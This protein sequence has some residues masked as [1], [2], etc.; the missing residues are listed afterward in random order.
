MRRHFN[1]LSV[2]L[3]VVM[4]YYAFIVV[5]RGSD[6]EQIYKLAKENESL[7]MQLVSELDDVRV[8]GAVWR[9][10]R[11]DVFNDDP[12]QSRIENIPIA[13]NNNED[14][15]SACSIVFDA[16][17]FDVLIVQFDDSGHV[18]VQFVRTEEH[19][20]GYSLYYLIYR[21]PGY[22]ALWGDVDH[23][24]QSALSAPEIIS[25]W[26]FMRSNRSE[27]N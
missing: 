14:F 23:Y 12:A 24:L 17:P 5:L 25:N 26:Y 20:A 6:E 7:L 9:I 13:L 10:D 3:L 2:V 19:N 21:A 4:L 16:Y 18:G 22:D 27:L 15:F 1:P 11:E 8:P